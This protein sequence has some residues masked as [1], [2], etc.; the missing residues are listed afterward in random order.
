MRAEEL[1]FCRDKVALPTSGSTVVVEGEST[2]VFLGA[3]GQKQEL[4]AKKVNTQNT[5]CIINA[6]NLPLP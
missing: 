5:I 3:N 2:L 1:E 4:T 6:P